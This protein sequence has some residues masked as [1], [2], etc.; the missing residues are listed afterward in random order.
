MR[1]ILALGAALLLAGCALDLE[2]AKWKRPQMMVQQVTAS[3]QECAR[4]AFEIGPGP[5]LVLGGLVDLVRL[6]VLEGR[7]AGG[8]DGCM[9]SRGYARVAE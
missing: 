2:A 9:T 5:D 6:A 1:P 4:Q 8:F 3:E 7:Q